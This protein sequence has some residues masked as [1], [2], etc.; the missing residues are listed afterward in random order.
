MSRSA[1]INTRLPSLFRTVIIFYY[2]LVYRKRPKS[3]PKTSL[4]CTEIALQNL[5]CTELDLRCTELDMYRSGNLY[6]VVPKLTCTEFDLPLLD[7]AMFHIEGT[8]RNLRDMRLSKRPPTD[9]R[10]LSE[11]RYRRTDIR[12]T[13]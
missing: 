8:P 3:V 12:A 6:P 7:E 13:L 2:L 9:S 11:K 4:W 5:W 10:G 1:T